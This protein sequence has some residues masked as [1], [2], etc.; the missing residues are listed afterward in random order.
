MAKIILTEEQF[1]KY[2]ETQVMESACKEASTNPK[3]INKFAK[4]RADKV[5]DYMRQLA[6]SGN[7]NLL[8]RARENGINIDSLKGDL[9]ADDYNKEVDSR[10]NALL[11]E[12][13]KSITEWVKQWLPLLRKC[14]TVTSK[15]KDENGNERE[16]S[17]IGKNFQKGFDEYKKGKIEREVKF[18]DK[19]TDEEK[20]E[21]YAVR[22]FLDKVGLSFLYREAPKPSSVKIRFGIEVQ[23]YDRNTPVEELKF[24]FGSVTDSEIRDYYNGTRIKWINEKLREMGYSAPKNDPVAKDSAEWQEAGSDIAEKGLLEKAARSYVQR[25]Y[26]M[27]FNI[28]G[29]NSIF[30]FGNKKINNDTLIINFT[31]AM[32]CPAWNKC[33][34]KDAC[35]A[36]TTEAHYDNALNRNLRTNLIWAQTEE[37]PNLMKMMASLIRACMIDYPYVQS[38]INEPSEIDEY[39]T[40]FEGRAR[41]PKVVHPSADS[42][43]EMTFAE[44]RAKYGEEAIELMKSRKKGEIIRLNEDGDFIGQWLVDAWEDLAK[45]FAMV[46]ITVTAYTCRGLNYNNIENMILNVSQKTLV[47]GQDG[48]HFAHFFY[49]I[50]PEDY[51]R[52]KETYGGENFQLDQITDINDKITP[53]YRDLID[54]NGELVGYYYK[55]PCGRGKHKY[56]E[57]TDTNDKDLVA[58]LKG[59]RKR[60]NPITIPELAFV[61]DARE[62]SPKIGKYNGK[63]YKRVKNENKTKEMADCYRCRI[64]YGRGGVMTEHNETPNPQLPVYVLVSVHGST[65][66]ADT[67][68]TGNH[69]I[70][71]HTAHQW[72]AIQQGQE[73]EAETG[74]GLMDAKAFAIQEGIYREEPQNDPSAIKQVVK[75]ATESVA[76]MMVRGENALQENKAKFYNIFNKLK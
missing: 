42:L 33:L 68:A 61:Y 21:I 69:L 46:G 49:A 57:I 64:C 63:Y 12:K 43:C 72:V 4:Q 55:C 73:V 26:G 54:T 30:S 28:G 66:D 35:Y 38:R 27:D 51:D 74:N 76:N 10:V 11:D 60:V 75:N 9:S 14:Y 17:T 67:R 59:E 53:V 32:R 16:V 36:R 37:D 1:V 3:Q 47:N 19:L 62:D 5:V 8:Q 7:E 2:I 18:F 31:A 22:E 13:N 23:S 39:P 71:G 50:E 6:K 58:A 24:D 25:T 52:L 41:K 40:L 65:K 44:V 20:K 48:S 56:E 15:E 29:D 34:L 45:D 70:N